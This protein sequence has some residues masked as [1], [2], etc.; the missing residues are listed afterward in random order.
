MSGARAWGSQPSVSANAER[1]GHRGRSTST[2][3]PG[4]SQRAVT[5]WFFESHH[6]KA[7]ASVLRLPVPVSLTASSPRMILHTGVRG[8]R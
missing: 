3:R 1:P 6:V 7:G 4:K 5:R 8:E 2:G